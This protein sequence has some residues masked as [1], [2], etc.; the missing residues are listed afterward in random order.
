MQET[1]RPI[2]DTLQIHTNEFGTEISFTD[3]KTNVPFSFIV[4]DDAE[5]KDTLRKMAVKVAKA[6]IEAFANDCLLDEEEEYILTQEDFVEDMVSEMERQGKLTEKIY[7]LVVT[8]VLDE[9]NL[10]LQKHREENGDPDYD[11]QE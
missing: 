4:R 7:G 6:A 5:V 2:S 9:L 3:E 1:Y 11:Y 10:R 8:Q